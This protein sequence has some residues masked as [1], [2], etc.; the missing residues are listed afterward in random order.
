MVNPKACIVALSFLAAILAVAPA[1]QAAD[2]AYSLSP[3]VKDTYSAI[4]AQPAVKKGLDF[5]KAD[6]NGTVAEQKQINSIPSPPFKEQKRAADYLKRLSASGLTNVAMDKEGNVC[7][8]MQGTGK[9]PKL[10]VAAHMDTVFPE[11]TNLA[12]T[13]KNGVLHAPGIADNA[14]GLASLLGVV[15]AFRIAGIKPV[16]DIMFCGNVGEEGLGD[17][18][19]VKALFRD[20][21]DI[22]GF[23][24]ID[25]TEAEGIVYLA[26]GSHRYEVTYKGPGGHSFQRFGLPSAIHA[27]GRAIARIADLETPKKPKTTFT[28][29]TVKGG[30]S[31]NSIAAEASMLMD[32]RSDSET[33]LLAFEAKFLDI[34]KKAAAEENTRWGSDKITVDIKLVGNRPAGTQPSD[35]VIVQTSWA[36]TNAVGLSPKLK[37][38]SST[39]TNQPLSLGIPA[40]TLASGG[41]EQGNHSVS[42]SWDP[43]NAWLGPQRIFLAI[44]GLAGMDGVSAPLLP[45]R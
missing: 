3:K 28:V 38:A 1:V 19:G 27:M 36:A 15:R 18:R 33:E 23:I 12:L 41:T 5:I 40:V 2:Q 17:L 32:M 34:V 21:K 43:A 31:V 39:D 14:R 11:G 9:R 35:A 24:A 20:N 30:T 25:G 8:T 45:K 10:L 7:G 26:T 4:T 37:G 44:I 22:D 13:E 42:E 6:H 16:G 29:G